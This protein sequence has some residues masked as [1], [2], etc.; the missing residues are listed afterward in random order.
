MVSGIGPR[1]SQLPAPRRCLRGGRRMVGRG[2]YTRVQSR[3]TIAWDGL[4]RSPPP[5]QLVRSRPG[6]RTR[7]RRADAEQARRRIEESPG[8]RGRRG[9]GVAS[10][11]DAGTTS[12]SR[13]SS[14]PRKARVR[15][16]VEP[17]GAGGGL[18]RRRRRSLLVRTSRRGGCTPVPCRTA[19]DRK[20]PARHRRTAKAA[21][22]PDHPAQEV[23]TSTSP[24]QNIPSSPMPSRRRPRR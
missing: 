12:T 16:G 17:I 7:R 23:A 11:L 21:D 24:P 22:A 3:R 9:V 20:R 4:R 10:N 1:G 14:R 5:Q 18:R 8:R 6:P 15:L 13:G 19:Y 2:S